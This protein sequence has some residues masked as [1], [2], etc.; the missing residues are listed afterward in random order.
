MLDSYI[1]DE[2][3]VETNHEFLRH[4]EDC[5]ACRAELAAH[6]ELLSQMRS[7]FKSAPEMQINPNFAANLKNDLRQTALRPSLWEKFKKG[8]L[9]GS[10]VFAAAIAVCLLVGISA[11][12]W[13]WLNRAAT[14]SLEIVVT[15]QKNTENS[16]QNLPLNSA[17]E[18]ANTANII[19]AAWRETLN[20]AVGDHKNCALHFRLKE[21]PISLTEAA[22]KYGRFYKD[23]DIAVKTALRRENQ[24]EKISG[25]SIGKIE[26]LN[27]H[28]CVFNNRRFAH[29]V[30]RRGKETISLLVTDDDLLKAAD[31][32][33]VN[34]TAENFQV[35][36]FRAVNH[37]VLIVS[38]L[39]QSENSA[40]AQMLLPA[41]RLHIEQAEA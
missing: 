5:P 36:G 32:P 9:T 37:A 40:V 4:L 6:R 24:T 2:L 3:L 19:Q 14:D 28:S 15:N 8:N 1:G 33:T 16:A 26:F 31:A 39:S 30:L 10:P 18:S 22:A 34:Q 11:A 20:L 7:A 41:I 38:D 17:N 29:V 25:Q 35:A 13:I 21:K 27:A 23:L 12:A